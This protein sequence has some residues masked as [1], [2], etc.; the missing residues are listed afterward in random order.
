VNYLQQNEGGINA[1][2]VQGKDNFTPF[3]V[4][5]IRRFDAL[6]N[7]IKQQNER[8]EGMVRN[9]QVKAQACLT[10]D[11]KLNAVED[12]LREFKAVIKTWGTIAAAAWSVLLI[13]VTVVID[14][15]IL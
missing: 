3:E 7:Q 15:F 6:E 9:E 1:V 10:S 11:A 8:I 5:L 13:V 14:K 4:Y 2:E 12:D